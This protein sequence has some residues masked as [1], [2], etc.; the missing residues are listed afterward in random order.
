MHARPPTIVRL[1]DDREF[2]V[3]AGDTLLSAALRAGVGFPHECCAGGCGACRFELLDGSVQDLWSDAPGLSAR[4]RARG[5]KLAC[6]SR[7]LEGCKVKVRTAAE[8]VPPVRPARRRLTLEGTTDLTGD[9]REFR[10][11]ASDPAHFRAGQFALLSLEGIDRPRAYSMS[12]LPNDD[13]SWQFIIRRVPGGRGSTFL[14][15]GLRPGDSVNVDGPYGGAWFREESQRDIICIAGGSGLAPA[16]SIARAASASGN[17]RRIH[18][19]YGARTPADVCGEAQL[20]QLEG[21]PDRIAYRVAVSEPDAE[22]RGTTGFIHELVEAEFGSRL[23]EFDFYFAG[24]P[25]MVTAV[26]EM[27]AVRHLVPHGQIH[28]DRFF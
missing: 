19:F 21:Y 22:W 3:D 10:F 11:R 1:E 4:D 17:V 20:A 26:Q 14:F 27:L 28:F 18:F 7:P 9:L 6:Q 2:A 15:D 5:R 25:P 13:G 8:Y 16:L 24:P 23:A 12:N